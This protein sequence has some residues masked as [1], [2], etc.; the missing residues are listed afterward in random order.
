MDYGIYK[1]NIT[2]NNQLRLLVSSRIPAVRLFFSISHTQKYRRYVTPGFKPD[3][4]V[5]DGSFT[6]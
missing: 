2:L 6:L 1:H 5:T 3:F 4:P